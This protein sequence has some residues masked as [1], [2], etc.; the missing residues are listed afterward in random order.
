MNIQVGSFVLYNNNM[1]WIKSIDGDAVVLRSGTDT[2]HTNVHELKCIDEK[3]KR[4][5]NVNTFTDIVVKDRKRNTWYN[6]RQIAG[7]NKRFYFMFWSF[8][9]WWKSKKTIIRTPMTTSDDYSPSYFENDESLMWDDEEKAVFY[10]PR[11]LFFTN[12]NK[13][14]LILYFNTFEEASEYAE[15]F[16]NTHKLYMVNLSTAS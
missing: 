6:T 14:P 2:I 16:I 12:N 3:Y 15:S 11:V 8:P 9:L 1:M 13:N 10:K 4:Y 5:V 7:E